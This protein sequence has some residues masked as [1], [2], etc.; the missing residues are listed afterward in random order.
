LNM[1]SLIFARQERPLPAVMARNRLLSRDH[2]ER[3]RQFPVTLCLIA[4][5]AP[6]ALSV[7]S[8]SALAA[9]NRVVVLENVN[10]VPM[11]RER[12]LERQSV[13]VRDGRIAQI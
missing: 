5:L 13:I 10:V 3:F 6:A 2:R 9:D 7:A 11:D 4:A 1:T 8:N 12:V